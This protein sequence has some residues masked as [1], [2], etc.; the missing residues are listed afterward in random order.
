MILVVLALLSVVVADVLGTAVL[1]AAGMFRP[2]SHSESAYRCANPM[3]HHGLRCNVSGVEGTWGGAS[4]QVRTNSLGFKDAEVREIAAEPAIRRVLLIGDS[5]TEGVGYEFGETFAGIVA[6]QLA[7]RGIEVLNAGC[8]TYSPV[9]YRRKVQHLLE[10]KHLRFDH[11]IVMLDLSDIVDEAKYYQL[12]RYGNVARRMHGFDD[13]FK[14]FISEHTILMNVLRSAVRA[15]GARAQRQAVLGHQRS[16]WTSDP[17]LWRTFGQPGLRLATRHLG[18]L[19]QLLGSRGIS[20]TLVVYPWPD[21][22]V[23]KER[24]CVQVTHWKSWCQ[25]KGVAFINLFPLFLDA[26]EATDVIDDYFI[27]ADM[28]WNDRGHQLVARELLRLARF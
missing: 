20:M 16:S 19:R 24:D 7:P 26:G 11:L 1:Q 3:F 18:A 25:Q 6:R 10:D 23:R 14:R 22:I 4:Y 8:S 12:D 5:F 27:P 28:H 9:I 21:Q 15:T 13:R 17:D 2:V